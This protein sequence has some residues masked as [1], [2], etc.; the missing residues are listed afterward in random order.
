MALVVD[1]APID[2]HILRRCEGALGMDAR[3]HDVVPGAVDGEDGDG[4]DQG[5]AGRGVRVL[6]QTQCVLDQRDRT[7][8]VHQPQRRRVRHDF[9]ALVRAQHVQCRGVD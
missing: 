1:H 4:H 3:M 6:L 8:F 7:G 9:L 2:M 5:I